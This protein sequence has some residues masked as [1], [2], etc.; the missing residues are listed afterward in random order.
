MSFVTRSPARRQGF[1]VAPAGRASAL[2]LDLS[3]EARPTARG[4]SAA[5]ART[6]EGGSQYRGFTIAGIV[7]RSYALCDMCEHW[8]DF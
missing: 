2:G 4:R 7:N 1:L 8:L 3:G 5:L 6:F